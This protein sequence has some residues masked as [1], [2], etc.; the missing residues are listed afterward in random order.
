MLAALG[1]SAAEKEHTI[2]GIRFV[3]VRNQKAKRRYLHIHGNETTAREV[4]REH[5]RKYRGTAFF[6]VSDARNVPVEG[7]C[8]IDPNRMFSRLG[9]EKSVRRVNRGIENAVVERCLAALDRDRA[10]FVEAIA[11]P[12]GGVLIAL[13]NNAEGYSVH[14]EVDISD[15]VALNDKEHPH[16]FFLATNEE[17]FAAI[18]RGRY[19][20][21]LQKTIR[22]EDGSFSVLAAGRGIRYVNIEAALGNLDV[23]RQMLEF[24]EQ[25]LH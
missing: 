17:D 15:R 23:Q 11:P 7:G 8:L 24:L 10:R 2:G 20:A 1:M 16:E 4:L 5:I 6:V 19:N 21:V 13:H 22:N 18:S 12:K 14:A 9:A 25:V 3:E